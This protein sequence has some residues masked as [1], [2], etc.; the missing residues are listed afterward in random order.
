MN[1]TY[2]VHGMHCQSCVQKVT[3]ALE[4]VPGVSSA[5]VCIETNKA[6]LTLDASVELERLNAAVG[7]VGP[8]SL[9][10]P[11]ESREPATPRDEPQESL[12][13]LGLIVGYILGTTALLAWASGNWSPT[14]LMRNFMGGFFLIFSFFKLLDL[15]GFADAYRS[16]DIIAKKFAAWSFV[17]PFAEL[18]LGAAY[19]L[20]FAPIAT[21]V[22]TLVLMLVGSVGV[23]QT[24]LNKRAIQ[25]ACLGTVL[26]LPM[27]KVTLAEDLSMAA[28]AAAM[29]IISWL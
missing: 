3:N 10:Q 4:A 15:Q 27:T 13:A 29:L 20:G 17:Y 14:S 8:Y 26:K 12:Y 1:A 25:C 21:N 16:Y 6:N 11:S 24:L 18:C 2:D 22:T 7:R 5:S 9:H 28:M 23:L 19:V